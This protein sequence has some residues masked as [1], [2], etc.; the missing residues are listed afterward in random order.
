MEGKVTGQERGVEIVQR[1]RKG[2][3]EKDRKKPQS[4][5]ASLHVYRFNPI[6]VFILRTLR[7]SFCQSFG[8]GAPGTEGP[9]KGAKL[10]ASLKPVMGT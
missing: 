1:D 6:F 3:E 5:C 7:C 2:Y 9:W 10:E 4:A 8:K